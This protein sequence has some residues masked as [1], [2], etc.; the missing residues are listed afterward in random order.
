L[1]KLF[2]IS[3]STKWL[4]FKDQ[5]NSANKRKITNYQWIAM[6]QASH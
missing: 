2:N 4:L 3:K 5:R 6:K 1:S